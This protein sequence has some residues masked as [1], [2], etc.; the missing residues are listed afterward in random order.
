MEEYQAR[1]VRKKKDIV[2]EALESDL[3]H[4]D[5]SDG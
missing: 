2:P 3:G 1:E 5:G 4:P